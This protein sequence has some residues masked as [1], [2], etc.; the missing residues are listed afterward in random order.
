MIFPR[1]TVRVGK[2]LAVV[3]QTTQGKCL[4]VPH[5]LNRSLTWHHGKRWFSHRL[6]YHLNKGK[7]PRLCKSKNN[8]FVLHTCDHSWCIEP[9]HLYLGN[10]AQNVRDK[11][12]RHPMAKED[13]DRARMIRWHG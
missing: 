3:K 1:K 5:T 6:S 10:S 8:G 13:L 2:C 12:N 11:F 7:I 4:G 9:E